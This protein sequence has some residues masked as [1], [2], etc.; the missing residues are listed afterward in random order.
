MST[1]HRIKARRVDADEVQFSGWKAGF[2][3]A[4]FANFTG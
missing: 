3:P 2:H 4:G 1:S